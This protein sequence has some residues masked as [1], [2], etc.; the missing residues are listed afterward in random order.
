MLEFVEL[1]AAGGSGPR[2]FSFN[3]NGSMVAVGL[4]ND[5]EVAILRRNAET[6]AIG[7]E[8]ARIGGIASVAVVIWDD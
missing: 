4:Q 1:A 2:Q 7:D 3:K 6:G 8:I 5:G